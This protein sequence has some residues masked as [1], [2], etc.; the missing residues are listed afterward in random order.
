VSHLVLLGL[1]VF[2]AVV[3]VGLAAA[4]VRGLQAWRTFRRFRRTVFKRLGE[5]EAELAK[6]EQRSAKAAE[7][8]VRLNA[9]RA[10]LQESLATAAV[11]TAAAGEAS[12]LFGRARGIIPRK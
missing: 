5:I 8:A 6:V 3:G 2:C 4:V 1:I 12:S 11:I 7:S 10:R 9:A